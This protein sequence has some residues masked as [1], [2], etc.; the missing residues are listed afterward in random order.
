LLSRLALARVDYF[1]R[2]GIA[3]LGKPSIVCDIERIISS[4]R[5]CRADGQLQVCYEE[6]MALQLMDL[7]KLRA[8]MHKFVYQHHTVNCIEIMICDVLEQAEAHF[9]VPNGEGQ[10]KRLSEAV[11]DMTVFAKIGDWVLNAIECTVEPELEL[12]RQTLLRLRQRDLYFTVGPPTDVTAL[13]LT[14]EEVER[15]VLQRVEPQWLAACTKHLRVHFIVIDF[16][17]R[18]PITKQADNPIDRVRFYNPKSEDPNR[19]QRLTRSFPDLLM[20]RSFAE[21][22]L[23][24]YTASADCFDA[25]ELGYKRWRRSLSRETTTAAS[26]RTA[27]QAHLTPMATGNQPSPQRVAQRLERHLSRTKHVEALGPVP[28]RRFQSA[29][30]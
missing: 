3:A 20:P 7:F 16:G 17:S 14:V 4:T 24:V 22:L 2:D 28:I 27:L 26:D 30:L 23:Y 11:D 19:A 10:R 5:V 12:S 25:L 18:D 9:T 29:N 15:G 6:K 13:R 8:W 1:V 21:K